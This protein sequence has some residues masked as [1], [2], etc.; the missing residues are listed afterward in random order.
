MSLV[1]NTLYQSAQNEIELS[2]LY[3]LI[4]ILNVIQQNLN[5]QLLINQGNNL[6]TASGNLFAIASQSYGDATL[7]TEILDANSFQMRDENGFFTPN[8]SSLLSLTI[9]PKPS[10]PS[11]GI[12]SV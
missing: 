1:Q 12:L 5:S 4:D 6:T 8:I 2:N 11:G 3:H 10:A 9:P 7:W